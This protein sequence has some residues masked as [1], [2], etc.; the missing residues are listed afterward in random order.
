M[1]LAPGEFFDLAICMETLEHVPPSLVEPYLRKISEVL[2][3]YLFVTAPVERG[4]GFLVKHSIKKLLGIPDLEF[5]LREF[6][7]STLGHLDR[8]PRDDHKGFDDRLLVTQ[9]N[10]YFDI[11]DMGGIWGFRP[12]TLNFFVGSSR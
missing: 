11:L 10:K 1:I 4:S 5:S 2:R 3:G 6:V 9:I 12:L 8:F 7:N